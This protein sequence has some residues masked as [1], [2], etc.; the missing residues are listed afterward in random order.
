ME[1]PTAALQ[2]TFLFASAIFL[3]SQLHGWSLNNPL[4]KNTRCICAWCYVW[5]QTKAVLLLR[6]VS[7]HQHN[8]FLNRYLGGVERSFNIGQRRLNQAI[9]TCRRAKLTAAELFQIRIFTCPSQALPNS[10]LD[11]GFKYRTV[12]NLPPFIRKGQKSEA[13]RPCLVISFYSPGLC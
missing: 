1:V 12:V 9:P 7:K 2:N 11:T 10:D 5:S 3:R 6:S 4:T 8:T 13:T